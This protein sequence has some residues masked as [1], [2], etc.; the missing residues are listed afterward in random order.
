MRKSCCS[1]ETRGFAETKVRRAC[2]GDPLCCAL[3]LTV[4][5]SG[6][7]S[8]IHVQMCKKNTEKMLRCDWV[9]NHPTSTQV[10]ACV[11]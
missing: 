7:S 6:L 10:E 9:K 3:C 8:L 4:R 5:I 11:W 1:D 2:S